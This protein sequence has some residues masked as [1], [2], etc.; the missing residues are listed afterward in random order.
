MRRRSNDPKRV[1]EEP[2][3]SLLPFIAL[4]IVAAVGFWSI[5][6]S[7]RDSTPEAIQ[8]VSKTQRPDE[9]GA[10][11]SKADLRTVFSADDYPAD[12]QRNGEQGTVQATLAIDAR[13]QVSGCTIVRSSGH[14]SLDNATCDILQRRARFSPARDLSGDAIPSTV[15]TPPV[16]WRLE[17]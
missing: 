4:A 15:T 3:R 10:R 2:P 13:G 6:Q 5:E 8:S 11:S 9:L 12:A 16:V 7:M 17:G 14:A 1:I